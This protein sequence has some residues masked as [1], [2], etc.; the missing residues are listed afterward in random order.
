MSS[1]GLFKRKSEA[2]FGLLC[3]EQRICIAKSRQAAEAAEQQWLTER[4]AKTPTMVSGGRD[5]G[6][7]RYR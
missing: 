5:G 1:S 7:Q 4:L 3:H 2:I 6:N